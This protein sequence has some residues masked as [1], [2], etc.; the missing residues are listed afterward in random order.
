MPPPP[1]S[2]RH[3]IYGLTGFYLGATALIWA[4]RVCVL[5]LTPGKS[6]A[7]AEYVQHYTHNGPLSHTPSITVM[8][9]SMSVLNKLP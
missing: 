4:T 1:L 9:V 2:L 3:V 5:D 8:V 7:S 6:T